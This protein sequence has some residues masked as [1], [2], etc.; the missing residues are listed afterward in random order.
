MRVE[1]IT[2]QSSA[3]PSSKSAFEQLS[4][5]E[6]PRVAAAVARAPDNASP[7]AYLEGLLQ[8]GGGAEALVYDQ[9]IPCLCFQVLRRLIQDSSNSGFRVLMSAVPCSCFNPI[10]MSET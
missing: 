10:M 9:R 2:Q 8:L 7:W 5:T 6:L 3:G 1:S 4:E